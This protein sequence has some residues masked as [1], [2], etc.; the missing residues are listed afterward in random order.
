MTR[1]AVHSLTAEQCAMMI[2]NAHHIAAFTGAGIST[3]AGIP[4]FRGPNGLYTTGKYNADQ[5]FEINYF[6]RH[7]EM[8]YEFSHDF[9]KL[10]KTIQPT[11]THQFLA[12]LEAD[13]RLTGLITQNIDALHQRAGSKNIAEVHG[14][15][16]SASCLNCSDFKKTEATLD[17]W[18]NQ[19][20]Q[21]P[22]SPV[23]ICSHCGGIVKPDVV[24]FGEPVRHLEKAE[25][26]VRTCDLL[27]VLGS[28]LTVYP[29]AFI[30]QLCS[31]PIIVINQGDVMLPSGKEIFYISSDLDG[32][33]KKVIDFIDSKP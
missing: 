24:F 11:F 13:G 28:S 32:F 27:L 1:S 6:R 19:I 5:V 2:S 9:I 23:V 4:D 16:W 3:A 20:K 31:A 14:S 12:H 33:F 17:W 7:P 30:P 15:Y 10:L 18:E 26:L 29:A 8:F 22:R 21:S 25:K